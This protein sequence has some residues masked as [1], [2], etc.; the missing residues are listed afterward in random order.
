MRRQAEGLIILSGAAP[1]RGR[2]QPVPVIE[3]LRGALG[4][5]EDRGLGIPEETMAELNLRLAQ[6][7][8]F[9]LADSDRLG[10]FVLD[11]LLHENL[12]EVMAAAPRGRVTDMGLLRQVLNGLRSL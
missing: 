10:L 5:I 12:V 6:P 9:D 2:R 8:E 1:G 3:V 11:D 4:E 7:P